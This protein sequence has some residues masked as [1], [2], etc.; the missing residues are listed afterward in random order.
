MTWNNLQ[1][2]WEWTFLCTFIRS[3]IVHMSFMLM[4][5]HSPK[6]LRISQL[7]RVHVSSKF[8]LML[9]LFT[10]IISTAYYQISRNWSQHRWKKT[11]IW[12]Q[13]LPYIGGAKELGMMYFPTKWKTKESRNPQNH[14][15]AM[16][17]VDSRF[18]VISRTHRWWQ[19]GCGMGRHHSCSFPWSSKAEAFPTSESFPAPWSFR[20]I[21]RWVRWWM[22]L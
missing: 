22:P 18:V 7:G 1:Y 8:V 5:L 2:L 15:V 11:R 19:L 6:T 13:H 3:F 14:R 12:L 17:L 9:L 16:T 21:R 10:G 20:W 4:Y